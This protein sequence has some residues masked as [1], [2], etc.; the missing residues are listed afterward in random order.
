MYY[1][2]DQSHVFC[3]H[4]GDLPFSPLPALPEGEAV[5]YLFR[6]PPL[7]GRDAF[8]VSHPRLL[9]DREDAE[10]LTDTYPEEAVD[11]SL[12]AA[13]V[14]DRVSAVNLEHPRWRELLSPLLP[15]KK[16]RVHLLALGDV[17]STLLTGLRLLGGDCIASIGICDVRPGFSQRWAFEME[18]VA[19]PWDYDAMPPVDI[20]EPD[21]LFQCDVFLFCASRFVPDTAVK[22]GDVRMAQ[23]ARNRELVVSYA[24]QARAAHFQGLFCVVSDP[25]DPLCRAALLESNR[26]EAGQFDYLGLTTRQVRGFGLGVMNARAA[27]YA[28]RDARFAAFLGDGR[29]FGPHGED[30]VVANSISHYDDALSQELTEKTVHAN[31]EMRALGFKPY[32][33]PA[34]S[35]GALS[36]LLLLRGAWHCSSVYLDGVFMGCKNRLTPAGVAIEQLPLPAPLLQRIRETAEKLRAIP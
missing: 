3:S 8:A 21:S 36:L 35:S 4:I 33:A 30:L 32:V 13:I 28:K 15:A 11:P 23:Y 10:T 17:G 9:T 25:V 22:T 29:T 26:D 12:R 1:Y 5:T 6:R 27:Y 16:K 7:Q 19:L 24:R 18:Q 34:L 2:T 31:L 20:V 14:A